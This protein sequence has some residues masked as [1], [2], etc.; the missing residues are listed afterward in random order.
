L[1]TIVV[2][3]NT[4]SDTTPEMYRV[5][6]NKLKQYY[7]N[8]QEIFADGSKSANSFYGSCFHQLKTIILY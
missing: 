6:Y 4:K 5:F 3:N 7:P 8:F 1:V 2:F